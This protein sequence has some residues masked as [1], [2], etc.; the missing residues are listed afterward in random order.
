ML[1]ACTH[2]LRHTCKFVMAGNSEFCQLAVTT[3]NILLEVAPLLEMSQ[4][5][6]IAS[7]QRQP[8]CT[9]SHRTTSKTAIFQILWVAA[10]IFLHPLQRHRKV[11]RS[12]T[13]NKSCACAEVVP[14]AGRRGFATF[15]SQTC[16]PGVHTWRC[17]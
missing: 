7:A 8:I 9:H 3:A 16:I 5:T 10:V 13:A 17:L 1:R 14:R 2:R 11:S 12:G 4:A 6:G 15:V